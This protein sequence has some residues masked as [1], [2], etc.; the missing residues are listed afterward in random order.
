L[1][2]RLFTIGTQ[3]ALKEPTARAMVE[4]LLRAADL[5]TAP[6][7]AGRCLMVQGALASGEKADSIRQELTTCR[8]AG[9]AELRRRREQRNRCYF[10]PL[11]PE[12][13]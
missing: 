4:R 10:L 9:E 6:R 12:L 5:N 3:E 2:F 11:R 1:G 7:N 13:V 8:T